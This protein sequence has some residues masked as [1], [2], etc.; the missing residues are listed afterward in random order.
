MLPIP[1]VF[2]RFYNYELV[3]LYPKKDQNIIPVTSLLSTL[4]STPM[5][6]F[7]ISEFRKAQKTLFGPGNIAIPKRVNNDRSLVFIEAALSEFSNEM[8]DDF[9]SRACRTIN[10]EASCCDMS[11]VN[12]HACLLTLYLLSRKSSKTF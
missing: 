10:G 8:M 11:K 6:R 2:P 1:R 5:I 7:W 12:S 9:K 4:H 3:C